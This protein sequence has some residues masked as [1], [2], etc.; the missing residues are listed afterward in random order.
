MSPTASIRSNGMA[1]QPFAMNPKG[2]APMRPRR[3]DDDVAGTDDGMDASTSESYSHRERAM[4]PEQQNRQQQQAQQRAKSPQQ[5]GTASRT[6][7][8]NGEMYDARQPPNMASV[9]G[10][11]GSATGR[12]SPAVTG[13]MS[14]AP[15]RAS[16]VVDRSRSQA[17]TYPGS[18]NGSP[19][20]NGVFPRG[21]GSVGSVAADLVRDLKAKDAELDGLKRQ[22]TW[23]KEALSKAAKAGYV[24]SD[25]QGAVDLVS[26]GGID[27]SMEDRAELL[28][29][30]KQFRAEMQV[31]TLPS[32]RKG[33]EY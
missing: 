19:A 20:L 22:M 7:S 21:N 12:G 26:D 11:N 27:A 5:G 25:K 15:G 8:P 4:S 23:M 30:F 9:M 28:F 2:K 6:V 33:F 14:P 24:L 10:I 31:G 29:K 17:D 13:R 3:E 18:Q 1:P 32:L 16:P